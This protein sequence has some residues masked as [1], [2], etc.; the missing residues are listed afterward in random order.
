MLTPAADRT[1]APVL[2]CLRGLSGAR[3]WL[4]LLSGR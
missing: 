1:L 3:S 2:A 4:M